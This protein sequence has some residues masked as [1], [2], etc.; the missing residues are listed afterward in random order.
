MCHCIIAIPVMDMEN[1]KS[2]MQDRRSQED[3]QGAVAG[4]MKFALLQLQENHPKEDY[5]EL[6]DITVIFLGGVPPR[7][8][9][10]RV[11]GALHHVRL[12]SKALPC[13]KI[14]LFRKEFP[15]SALV[16]KITRYVC[17]FVVRLYV[18]AWITAPNAEEAP[19][20][21][22][23]FFK[24]LY[25]YRKSDCGISGTALSK[26]RNHLWYLYPVTL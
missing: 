7:G 6:L 9:S 18:E 4:I 12:M 13:L 26:Y 21:D 17:L 16:E 2:G 11:P 14:F 24:Y 10:F 22:L 25:E 15:L 3:I 23:L 19:R 5:R 8:M 1:Y 20:R